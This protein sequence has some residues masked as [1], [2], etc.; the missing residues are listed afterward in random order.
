MKISVVIPALNEAAS[1]PRT[2]LA[3]Q[4]LRRR[5]HEVIVVDGGSQ[6]ETVALAHS[7]ADQVLA[8]PA[9]R[10]RQM[11]RGA[12]AA[13]GDT[14]LFLHADT[15]VPHDI[16]HQIEH[17]RRDRSWGRFDLRIEGHAWQLPMVAWF[18][19]RRSRITGVATG[20]QGIF[21]ARSVFEALG[22]YREIDLMED[23]A[24]TQRLRKISPPAIPQGRLTTSG[25]RWDLLGAWRTIVLMWE[26][27]FLFWLGT[28][29]YRLAQLYRLP[30]RLRRQ[31]QAHIIIFAKAPVAGFA[32]TRLIPG[33][34]AEGAARIAHRLLVNAVAEACAARLGPVTL[35]TTPST[36]HPIFH[37]LAQQY[38]ITLALQPEGNLG[39]RMH[40]TFRRAFQDA[41]SQPV[42]LMGTDAPQLSAL[43]LQAAAAAL[44]RGNRE[45]APAVFVPALDGGYALVGLRSPQPAIF[46]DI[47][48]S[49]E[50]VLAQTRARAQ[51]AGIRMVCLPP[52]S[53]VDEPDDLSVVP[54]EWLEEITSS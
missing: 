39:Q 17:A 22:G 19:N 42:L 41:P 11:N 53:D 51:A 44:C 36:D 40:Q 15:L 32:K 50:Q 28:D 37:E 33:L 13:S 43:R 20:D 48:W 46:E 12:A 10:A 23:V 34:G 38:P 31:P 54:A 45:R 8:S 3:L 52:L 49:T 4:G 27:R 6:D 1:L 35:C 7:Q 2:L 25:R 5:G 30:R 47:A 16:D 14:L 9:G 29:P 24:L 26:L 18:I 21:V